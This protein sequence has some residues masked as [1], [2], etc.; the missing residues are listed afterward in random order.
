MKK[1]DDKELED[2]IL[3]TKMDK[4]IKIIGEA[5]EKSQ[6]VRNFI[7]EKKEGTDEKENE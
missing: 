1:I 6:L 5:I 2:F 3:T 7:G 4:F